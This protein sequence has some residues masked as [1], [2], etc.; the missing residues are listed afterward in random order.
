MKIIRQ[1]SDLYFEVIMSP[2]VESEPVSGGGVLFD[3]GGVVRVV[4]TGLADC[5]A[6]L[7]L[8]PPPPPPHAPRV[9]I[10]PTSMSFFMPFT[11]SVVIQK[12][13]VKHGGEAV[14]EHD[15]LKI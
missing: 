1:S 4:L 7:P 8:S 12:A 11:L 3:G 14:R 9:S 2:A 6:E 13:W 10:D 5:V 15:D